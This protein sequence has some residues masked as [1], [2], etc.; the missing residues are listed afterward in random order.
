[1]QEFIDSNNYKNI[2]IDSYTKFDKFLRNL[3][4]AIFD[5][6]GTSYIESMVANIPTVVYLSYFRIFSDKMKKIADNLKKLGILHDDVNSGQIFIF[7][8]L[9]NNKI[10]HWWYSSDVQDVRK[11]FLNNFA[12]SNE[13][14]LDELTDVLLEELNE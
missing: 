12:K 13:N 5:H 3:K 8:L 9:K 1:M 14:W 7:D 11:E 10:K 2:V 6:M 4:L